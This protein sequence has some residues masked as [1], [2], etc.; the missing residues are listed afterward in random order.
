MKLRRPL[1][2][3]AVAATGLALVAHG[4]GSTPICALNDAESVDFDVVGT[5]GP[6]GRVNVSMKDGSCGL[7]I[8]GDDVGVPT[9]GDDNGGIRSGG[10]RTEGK[11]AAHDD[12]L[13]TCSAYHVYPVDSGRYEMDCYAEGARFCRSY[14]IEVSRGCDVEACVVP[15]CGDGF[16]LELSAD[17]CCPHCVECTGCVGPEPPP[18]PTCDET[19]CPTSC[20]DGFELTETGDDC[21]LTCTPVIDLEACEAGR[22]E[23]ARD[24]EAARADFLPCSVDG[25]CTVIQVSDPCAVYCGLL[26]SGSSFGRPFSALTQ[27][28]AELCLHCP[29]PEG[30]CSSEPPPT[31][32]CVEGT[33]VLADP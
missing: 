29:P 2:S 20:E 30:Q 8:T 15:D 26:V 9:H 25:E 3:F 11:V 24:F 31:A 27:S 23:H 21:C 17:A 28:A 4:G 6:A 13:L 1:E 22:T 14:F 5:C 16:T 19:Q 12:T 32:R 33:C 7:N 18:E 10:W